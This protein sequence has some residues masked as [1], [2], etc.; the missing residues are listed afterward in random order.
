[1]PD[2]MI[3]TPNIWEIRSVKIHDKRIAGEEQVQ[4]TEGCNVYRDSGFQG[5]QLAR[6]KCAFSCHLGSFG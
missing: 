6:Q 2:W 5:H 1:M 3:V 4:V